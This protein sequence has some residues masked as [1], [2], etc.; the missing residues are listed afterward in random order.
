MNE[1]TVI[2]RAREYIESCDITIPVNINQYLKHS[3]ADLKVRTDLDDSEAQGSFRSGNRHIIYVNGAHSEE[4]QRFTILH[5]LAHIELKLQSQ[6][7]QT[8]SSNYLYRYSKRPKEEILCDV[9][10]AECLLPYKY[11]KYDVNKKDIGLDAVYEI[12]EKYKASLIC[13]ASRF[14]VCRNEPCIFV[15]AEKNVIRYVSSS[16]SAREY[17]IWIN[18]GIDVPKGSVLQ[19]LLLSDVDERFD[20]VPTYIW[21]DADLKKN[22]ILLEEAKII[23]AWQQGVA[24]IWTEDAVNNGVSHTI[25]DED[26]QLL[27]ELDGILP[28]P[29]KSRRKK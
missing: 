1:L 29:S 12:A 27:P 26:D 10:A 19:G 6:H 7:G 23:R 17:G 9:F 13:T 22:F 15:L 24:L 25:T 28:W 20:E 21:T 18:I 2:M 4:R 16:T 11:F 14:A 8:L 3:N 5:E